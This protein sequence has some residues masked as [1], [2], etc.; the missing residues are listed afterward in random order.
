MSSDKSLSEYPKSVFLILG[1]EFCERF[2]Y[3]GMRTI[4]VIYLTEWLGQGYDSAVAIFHMFTMMS[5]FCPLMGAIIADG[6][7]GRY[8]TILYISLVYA[9]GT[10]V[11]SLTAFPPPE[12]YGPVIGLLLISLGT[13]GIKPCVTAFGGDQ[14]STGQEKWRT[15]FFSAFY[16]MINCGS[17][18]STFITP[19]LRADVHCIKDS[20]YPLAFGV[21]TVLM[22]TSI[23]IFFSGRNHYKH[24]PPTG[25]LFGQVARCVWRGAKLRIR[26]GK[27]EGQGAH[28]MDYATDKFEDGFVSDVKALLNVLW[29]FLPLPLFWALFDQQGSRWTLQAVDMNGDVGNLGRLKPDQMQVLNPILIVLLIPVFERVIY[30]CLDRVRVPNKPLQRIC[31]GMLLCSGSFVLAGFVQLKLETGKESPLNGQ[32]G[33]TFLNAAS[34]NATVKTSFY[35][36][37][38]PQGEISGAH[39]IPAGNFELKFGCDSKSSWDS[40]FSQTFTTQRSKAYRVVIFS[41]DSKNVS[42]AAFPD[43][44]HHDKEGKSLVRYVKSL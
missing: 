31:V 44:R 27:K 40:S 12:M 42:A 5:Y 14:F 37:S 20:C 7:L 19:V 21:P 30:P 13:G 2:N 39:H 32:S 8:K 15:S 34:C 16:F 9:A 6:Y 33:V 43:E 25:N 1:T 22:L 38:L 17:M 18:L 23:V 28:W 29:L 36:G 11:L 10:L 26:N 4:L 41:I 35:S 3:Y 24:V